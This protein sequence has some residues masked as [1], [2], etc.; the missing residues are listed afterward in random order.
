MGKSTVWHV[1][2]NADLAR[3]QISEQAGQESVVSHIEGNAAAW[4]EWLEQV[5]SFAF[6][7]KDGGHVTALKERRGG[8]KSYWIA[9]RKVDGKLKRKYLGTS[10]E[11]TLAVLEQGAALLM[12]TEPVTPSSPSHLTP[13]STVDANVAPSSQQVQ[14]SLLITKLLVPAPAHTLLLRHRLFA[15]LD[16]GTR[17]PLTLVSA[18]AGF[19]KTSLLESW[20]QSRRSDSCHVAWVSLD[21]GDDDVMRFWMYVLTALE[22]CQPG[23]GQ[24]ALTLLLAPQAQAVDAVLTTLINHLSEATTSLVLILDDYHVIK[25]PVIHT[26][27]NFLLEHQPS[28]LHLLLST[29]S[30]PPLKL[31]RLRARGL[32]LEVY[33]EDLRC[34]R[35]EARQFLGQVMD[36]RLQEDVLEQVMSRTEGWLVGLQLLGLSLRGRADSVDILEALTGNQRYIVDYLTEEVLRQQSP[37]TQKFL[38]CTSILDPLHGSLCDAVLEQ[39]KS[40]EILEELERAN[41]FVCS[42]DQQRR[43]FRYHALFAEVLHNHLQ[44]AARQ[45]IE[46]YPITTLHRRASTWYEQHHLLSEAIDHA[47]LSEDFEYA[48][49]LM[50]QAIRPTFTRG[51]ISLL[52]RWFAALPNAVLR[53]HPHL[54]VY[55]AR[56]LLFNGQM[57]ATTALLQDFG[58]SLTEHAVQMSAEERRI[59]MGEAT[60]IRAVIAY[61]HNDV[62][63]TRELCQQALRDLPTNHH[64]LGMVLLA[65]GSAFWLENEVQSAGEALTQACDVCRRT[66][67]FYAMHVAMSY[68]GQVRGVQG[69]LSEAIR[70]YR[71]S[72]ELATGQI[73]EIAHSGLHVGL[74]VL[75]Y[76]RNE[77]EEAQRHLR[78]GLAL[79]R[80]EGNALVLIGG[81]L[82]L[83]RL[84]HALGNQT[85]VQTLMQEAIQLAQQHAITWTWVTPVAASVARLRLLQGNLEAVAHW[86]DEHLL[87]D[88]DTRR[89]PL[90]SNYL[91]AV[92]EI[93]LARIW[94]AQGKY[95]QALNLL[96]RLSQEAE[97]T[98]RMGHVLEILVLTALTYQAQGQTGHALTVLTEALSLA[99]P[100]GYIRRFVDEGEP[101]AALLSRVREQQRRQGP[102]PY[103]DTVLAAFPQEARAAKPHPQ[104]GL[105]DPLSEREL[106]VLRELAQGAPNQQIADRLVI[107]VDTVKRHVSNILAKLEV[108]NRTQAVARARSLGLLFDEQ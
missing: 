24:A 75:L 43:W 86:A 16:E 83:A 11:V 26:T 3:Y 29:R 108:S 50:N 80:Q 93:I 78:R 14:P 22:T 55:Y 4:W 66:G 58:T 101:M 85:Q 30:E 69:Q 60:A 94:L 51:E 54:L 39:T 2:W 25:E 6:Q 35:E 74:G 21:E 62:A 59:L 7:S 68:L 23:V 87:A 36:I 64:L 84:M 1:T 10:R 12:Q 37:S 82:T 96:T 105:L 107:T 47:L 49:S 18:P 90:G 103:L 41:V 19:G 91:H 46:D 104:Q 32:L 57:E 40:Q 45:Q 27:L 76:E 42:I 61:M 33:E 102:T 70:L 31:S 28:Q 73:S 52:L 98:G 9:Y 8:G 38:L 97:A 72:L 81:N 48:A 99:R 71:E 106:E 100:E 95:T 79:G 88:A 63:L 15:L 53:H 34:T 56:I 67:N 77:L 89:T 13:S 17:H 20:V 92:E 65:Q 44:K 5:S